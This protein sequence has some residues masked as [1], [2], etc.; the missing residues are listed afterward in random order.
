VSLFFEIGGGP[1][2]PETSFASVS[3]YGATPELTSEA[4]VP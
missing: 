2:G 1:F 3:G 4:S